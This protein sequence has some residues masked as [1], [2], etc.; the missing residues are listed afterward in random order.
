VTFKRIS[1]I[2]SHFLAQP[3]HRRVFGS[4]GSGLDNLDKAFMCNVFATQCSVITGSS[5]NQPGLLQGVLGPSWTRFQ[6]MVRSGAIVSALAPGSDS[7]ARQY[8]SALRSSR[9]TPPG[10]KLSFHSRDA[11]STNGGGHA[12]DWAECEPLV[13]MR[14]LLGTTPLTIRK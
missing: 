4:W 9:T 8:E 3:I 12:R 7:N 14:R 10:R 11:S 5:R 6:V 1:R 2:G 13:S